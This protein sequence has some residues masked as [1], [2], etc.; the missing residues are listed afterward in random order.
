MVSLFVFGW[1]GREPHRA[2]EDGAGEKAGKDWRKIPVPKY[3]PDNETIKRDIA[4]YSVEIEHFDSHV[5][6]ALRT[7]D[8]I[9]ELD[10]TIVVMTSD[11]GMPFPRVKG[12]IYEHGFHLPMALRWGPVEGGR[13]IEDFISVSDLAP[14]FL[15]A[16]AIPIPDTMT[17]ASFLDVL[18]SSESGWVDTGR[19]RML[20]G[21]ERH[22]LGRPNNGGYPVRAIRT[23]EW[24]YIKNYE[25]D[26]WPAGNPRNRLPQL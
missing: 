15:E 11:H 2:Y 13:V 20:I 5:G 8:E 18:R 19:N 24:L 21:K 14:T 1:E 9:G 7:L 12:Q 10:N 3:Y 25:P 16:A 23:K 22:D 4:D 17:G 6:R 26:R